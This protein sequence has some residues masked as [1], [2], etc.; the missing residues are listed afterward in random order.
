M[1]AVMRGGAISAQR[2]CAVIK[3]PTATGQSNRSFKSHPG[4]APAAHPP[5]KPHLQPPVAL[6]IARQ[7]VARALERV[8]QSVQPVGDAVDAAEGAAA[9]LPADYEPYA[10]GGVGVG[11]GDGA[12]AC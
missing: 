7:R 9:N 12:G 3:Q 10:V 11:C 1:M 5:Q 6:R 2:R 8:V 4:P